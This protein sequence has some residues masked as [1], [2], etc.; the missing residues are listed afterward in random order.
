MKVINICFIIIFL[1]SYSNS[2]KL[3]NKLRSS[4]Q[5]AQS[6]DIKSNSKIS[7]DPKLSKVEKIEA[8]LSCPQG[9]LT[10]FQTSM[11]FFDPP[12][13]NYSFSYACSK[14]GSQSHIMN[15]KGKSTPGSSNFNVMMTVPKND[16]NSG[17][18]NQPIGNSCS[19]KNGQVMVS[20]EFYTENKNNHLGLRCVCKP[21]NNPLTLLCE[22]K[23]LPVLDLDGKKC[24]VYGYRLYMYMS[25]LQVL[26]G[27][28]GVL[29]SVTVGF[30]DKLLNCN[31]LYCKNQLA[32][33]YEYCYNKSTPSKLP[34][35]LD[36]VPTSTPNQPIAVDPSILPYESILGPNISSGNDK[37]LFKSTFSKM[38]HDPD[39]QKLPEKISAD[40]K[41]SNTE[42]GLFGF[43]LKKREDVKWRMASYYSFVYGCSKGDKTDLVDAASVPFEGTSGSKRVL[44]ITK[45]DQSGKTDA[46]IGNYCDCPSNSVMSSLGFYNSETLNNNFALKCTCKPVRSGV[47]LK[48]ESVTIPEINLGSRCPINGFAIYYKMKLS[49]FQ[50]VDKLLKSFTI[51]FNDTSKNCIGQVCSNVITYKYEFCYNPNVPAKTTISAGPIPSDDPKALASKPSSTTTT[52]TSNS[53]QS[54]PITPSWKATYGVSETD[55]AF[56]IKTHN[57]LR[58]KIASQ[59]TEFGN[60]FPLASN[61]RQVYWSEEIAKLA[62]QHADK[63]AYMHSKDTFRKT[64]TFSYIGENI[65]FEAYSNGQPSPNWQKIISNWYGE[66]KDFNQ[67][68]TVFK[69]ST[70][71]PIG[72]F[73]QVVWAETYAIGCGLSSYPQNDKGTFFFYVCEYGP[74]ANVIGSPIYLKGNRKC[75]SGTTN[76]NGYSAL[77]CIANKCSSNDYLL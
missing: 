51:G 47:P 64:A 2:E 7:Y 68:V 62:Q 71:A 61:M 30:N 55:K 63:K 41:C 75:A 70:G 27:S 31:S 12:T 37:G 6:L 16:P 67:D 3:R 66:I 28:T 50:G 35:V 52:S 1:F 23:Q 77:C 56:I 11:T 38:Q 59:T 13:I 44:L 25:K 54:Q 74:G 65:A 15:Q 49:I 40:I 21:V 19:C 45:K 46:A 76:S 72:H 48:C 42:G 17:N 60:K 18:T 10:G 26:A 8:N 43:E 33:T 14:T 4:T 39:K 20:L 24:P 58:N 34:S 53:P 29:K 9:A 22:K 36:V 5:S 73:T 69:P 32:L 57:D